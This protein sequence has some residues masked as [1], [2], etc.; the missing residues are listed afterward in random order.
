MPLYDYKIATN[1]NNAAG[2]T[3]FESISVTGGED[4]HGVLAR[5]ASPCYYLPQTQEPFSIPFELTA[6]GTYTQRGYSK[7]ILLFPLMGAKAY[8]YLASTYAQENTTYHGK[9]T[10]RLR[11]NNF[12]SYSNYNAIMSIINAPKPIFRMSKYWLQDI[13]VTF[14]IRDTAS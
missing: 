14:L 13:T 12:N 8:D 2:L 6:G 4:L 9:V 10:V 7:A 1:W 3:N 11:S 5:I